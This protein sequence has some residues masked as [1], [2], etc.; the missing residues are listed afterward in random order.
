MACDFLFS[1]TSILFAPATVFALCMTAAAVIV[2]VWGAESR[3][4]YVPADLLAGRLSP[5]SS[6]PASWEV[7]VLA[8]RLCGL[9][10]F[11]L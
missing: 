10:F 9:A 3:T 2:G 7:T 8:L 6:S 5:A 11:A 4:E 1:V